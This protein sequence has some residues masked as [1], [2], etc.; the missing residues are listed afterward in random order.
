M[1]YELAE[2][3]LPL[4]KNCV[5]E[6][7]IFMKHTQAYD[8][9]KIDECIDLHHTNSNLIYKKVCIFSSRLTIG[10]ISK[11]WSKKYLILIKQNL[12][13]YLRRKTVSV[14]S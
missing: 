5:E 14:A 7:E 3:I 10:D 6:L 11:I 4:C 12:D 2:E 13:F 9:K 1:T 8:E